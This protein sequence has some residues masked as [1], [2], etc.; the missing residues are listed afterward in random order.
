MLRTLTGVSSLSDRIAVDAGVFHSQENNT[1]SQT[2]F[3][4]YEWPSDKTDI[5]RAKDRYGREGSGYEGIGSMITF[6]EARDKLGDAAMFMGEV[7]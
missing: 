3:F 4:E 1:Q 2:F 5:V 6:D 7:A